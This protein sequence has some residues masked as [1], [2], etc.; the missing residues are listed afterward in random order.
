ME[1]EKDI[2][3]PVEGEMAGRAYGELMQNCVM[4]DEADNLYLACFHE[5]A[6]GIE[7]GMLLRIKVGATEFDTSYN[8]Y[9]NADGKLMTV[10]YLGNNKALVY[11]RN[12]KA[13]ISDKAAAAGIKKPTAIDAFSHYY[14]VIDLATGTKTRLSYD[15]KEIG[16][17][18]GRFS[19]RSVIFNN[20][21][22]IGV[23]TEEDANAVIYIYDIKTGNVEKGAE[24]D[25]RFYFD[26]IR[27]IEND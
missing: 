13:P 20:K 5:E 15:G 11:A 6:S 17:S 1:V 24:V 12:D 22:Y 10:Q 25:G 7:K 3:S 18:G 2:K 14:T 23:N 9:Q 26:M 19:Q 4:Y 16:Y 21:A 27:V 8:G